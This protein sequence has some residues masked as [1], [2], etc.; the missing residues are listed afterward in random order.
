MKERLTEFRNRL[1]QSQHLNRFRSWLSRSYENLSAKGRH[2]WL[3]AAFLLPAGML[4]GDFLGDQSIWVTT[5]YYVYNI[6]QKAPSAHPLK[7]S[8][9]TVVVLI[10]DEDYWK[11]ELA[12]RTPLKRD[13]L[14]RLLLKLD[15]TNPA[16]IALD[17]DLG[18]Q[19]A[20][21]TV[22]EHPD[23]QAETK[24]LLTAI[25]SVSRNR[26][27]V[28]PRTLFM[29]D[30]SSGVSPELTSDTDSY[31]AEPTVFDGYN[32]ESD[33]VLTGYVSL[34]YDVRQVPL[35]LRL[36]DGRDQDSFAAAIVKRLDRSALQDA[37][38]SDKTALPYGTFISPSGFTQISAKQVFE[39]EPDTLKPWLA[40]NAVLVG[41]AWHQN[42]FERGRK[43]DTHL[44]PAGEIGGVFV[45]ANNVEA[46]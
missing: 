45:H 39:S 46:L 30:F 18:S 11:G 20:D 1:K 15:Q 41:G 13:Y 9:R 38:S 26:P 22:I 16:V 29:D 2:Y 19:T 21:K 35:T 10:G 4:V 31:E 32:F 8:T 6:L 42:S 27:V 44:T 34:P 28:L 7:S 14:A 36:K 5:R 43:V 12:R 23:Y 24:E 17:V 37:Q 40:A 33:N 3:L 25:K